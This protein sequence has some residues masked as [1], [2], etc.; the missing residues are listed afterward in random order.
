VCS[1]TAGPKPRIS[2]EME[3]A[4]EMAPA[5]LPSVEIGADDEIANRRQV[6]A[7]LYQEGMS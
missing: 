5:A 3:T 6:E 1:G 7:T 4:S 2:G